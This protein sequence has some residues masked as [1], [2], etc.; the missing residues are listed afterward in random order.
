[1]EE[2]WVETLCDIAQRKGEDLQALEAK[3]GKPLENTQ[4][5]Y[6]RGSTA[7]IDVTGPIFRYANLFTRISGATATE[8]LARDFARADEDPEI[9]RIILNIDSPGGQ[10]PGIAELASLIR[11]SRTEVIAYIDGMGASAA[12]WIA[13]AA[14]QVVISRTAEGGS[15]GAIFAVSVDEEKNTL[16]IVSKQSP[17]KRLDPKTASGLADLQE[18]ID[19]IAQVFVEDVAEFRGVS[20]DKVLSDFGQGGLLLGQAAVDAGLADRV[21]TFE[22]LFK[23]EKLMAQETVITLESLS[24]NNPELV[25]A[26]T[27][28]GYDSGFAAGVE[29]GKKDEV[30]RIKDVKS[31]LIPGHEA[32]V[33]SMMFDGISTKADAALA[34]VE[35]EKTARSNAHVDFRRTAP[36]VVP[37]TEETVADP[38]AG[39]SEEEKLKYEFDNDKELQAKFA[40]DFEAYQAYR[41]HTEGG[42]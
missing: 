12:Y 7:V 30:T 17:K 1:M 2:S 3:I 23:E 5:V 32:L 35:A 25:Q 11:E 15:I 27:K 4:N 18:R 22:S 24:A 16:T 20:V 9:D 13:A 41:E 34:I 39:M 29:Q 8:F 26:I 36:T 10:A 42:V 28:Q 6:V 38:T 40:G 21:G 31:Q 14:N 19:N 37:D 33:E